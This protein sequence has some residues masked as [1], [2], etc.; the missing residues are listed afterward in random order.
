[1]VIA[2]DKSKNTMV[3]KRF[4]VPEIAICV[5]ILSG[6]KKYETIFKITVKAEQAT[7]VIENLSN[8]I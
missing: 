2:A 3:D 7:A 1:M 8:F 5:T 6:R 4:P